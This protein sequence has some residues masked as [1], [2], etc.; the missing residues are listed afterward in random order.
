MKKGSLCRLSSGFTLIEL[1]VVVA[2]IALLA[3]IL[4]PVISS[5]LNKARSTSSSNNL[6][7]IHL[8]MFNHITDNNGKFPLAVTSASSGSEE[9]WR[10]TVWESNYGPFQAD[11][12]SAMQQSAYAKVMWC[13]VMVGMH[14]QQ[15][16]PGGRG[17]YG[18]N[19]Y[20]NQG[21][22]RYMDASNFSGTREP[23]IMAGNVF[24]NPHG[25]FGTN[26]EINKTEPDATDWQS[27]AYVYGGGRDAGLA[28]FVDGHV[29]QVSKEA[30]E[31]LHDLVSDYT[32]FE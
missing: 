4:I 10:R 32:S 31:A 17:S 7:Q 12:S 16:H 21:V 28:L 19:P 5:S 25:E 11:A 1:L 8:L 2:I 3:A 15:Q 27:M 23:C 13:P 24:A 18:M 9:F 22:E 6:K 14:G 20:F 26:E 30:G 29:E